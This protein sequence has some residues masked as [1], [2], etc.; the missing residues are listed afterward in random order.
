MN[1]W[2]EVVQ[3]AV[4]GLA[5]QAA[6]LLPRLVVSFLLLLAGVLIA[7]LLQAIVRTVLGR[8]GLDR[9]ADQTGLGRFLSRMGHENPASHLAGF[10]VFW[11]VL[12]VF[13][14][15]GADAQGLPAVSEMIGR[16]IAQLPP[17]A[18]AAL[19]LLLGM[20]FA[21]N[22]RRTVEGVTE[23]SRMA[24]ARPLGIGAY[25]LVAALTIVVA[26]SGLGIDFT[27]VTA[28]V[29]VLL[30]TLGAGV[31]IT[32]GL[33]SRDV[34]RNTISGIYA[35]KEIKVGDRIRLDGLDGEVAAVGQILVTLTHEGRTWLVPYDRILATGVEIVRR[36]RGQAAH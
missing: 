22:V 11:T 6:M 19:V 4:L 33:G 9:L 25:Y 2:S 26:L 20:S 3:R 12:A 24:S 16:L 8:A 21:R 10:V 1:E 5:D 27:I 36:P 14:V 31:A 7:F 34:A 13:L 23:R 28:V 17:I 35:R 18:L 15:T 30:A 29:V 32:L